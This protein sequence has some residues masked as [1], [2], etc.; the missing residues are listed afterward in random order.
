MICEV[1]NMSGQPVD[2]VELT[3]SIFG[4]EPNQVVMHQALVRQLAN[5]RQGTQQ[6]QTRSEVSR[7]GAKVWRQKGTGR[8]RQGSRRGPHWVG[9]GVAFAPKPRSYNK[10]MPKKMRRLAIRSTLAA[11]AQAGQLILIDEIDLQKTKEAASFLEAVGVGSGIVLVSQENERVKRSFRNLP[12]V[13][14]LHW[15]YVNVRDVLTHE[16][17]IMS[18]ATWRRLEELWG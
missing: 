12:K 15:Q 18:V 2:Q 3:E 8:A 5:A 4:I 13:R 6:S 9:G 10:R 16:H 11:K 17:L 7:T 1:H 14:T